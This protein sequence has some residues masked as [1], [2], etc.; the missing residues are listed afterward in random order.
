MAPNPDSS[1]F[2]D[3]QGIKL[4]QTVVRIFLYYAWA[5]NP[6]LLRSLNDISCV[7]DRPTKD[8]TE[9]AKWFLDY[10]ATYPNSIIRYHVSQTVLQVDSDAA[11]LVM[12]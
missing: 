10:A 4:I 7:Q 9:N 5:L 3:Q 6:T 2:L 8:T 12:P 1:E 11:Y